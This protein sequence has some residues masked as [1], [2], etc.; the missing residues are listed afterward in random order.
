MSDWELV[1]QEYLSILY[2]ICPELKSYQEPSCQPLYKI[3]KFHWMNGTKFLVLWFDNCADPDCVH[4][5][6]IT[7]NPDSFSRSQKHNLYTVDDFSLLKNI[8]NTFLE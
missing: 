8:V 6:E 3:I 2:K 4:I 5:D 1:K 7:C